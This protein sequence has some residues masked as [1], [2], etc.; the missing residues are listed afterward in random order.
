MPYKDIS[1]LPDNIKS[2]LP[3]HAQ[4]IYCA[5]FN[6]AWNEYAEPDK[7]LGDESQEEAAHKV[8]WAA[9][10][11]EYA[12]DTKTGKWRKSPGSNT[13]VIQKEPYIRN[14]QQRVNTLQMDANW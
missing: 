2:S 7:R 8:A 10:E 3:K 4:E 6:S 13:G 1:Q 14:Q 12:K 11:T 9:V 5:S